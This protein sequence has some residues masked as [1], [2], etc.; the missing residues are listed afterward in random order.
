MDS[1]FESG[2][3]KIKKNSATFW[4]GLTTPNEDI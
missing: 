4:L 1:P 2:I 3:F